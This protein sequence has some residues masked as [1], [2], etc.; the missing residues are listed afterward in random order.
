MCQGLLI[1]CREE[2]V[3][4]A[5]ERKQFRTFLMNIGPIS[6]LSVFA[7]FVPLGKVG[8]KVWGGSD[9]LYTVGYGMLW[10]TMW[11]FT[12]FAAVD[13]A[14]AAC[15]AAMYFIFA[16]SVAPLRISTRTKLGISGGMI[17]DCC[18]CFFALP[19]A[20][21]QMAAEDLDDVLLEGKGDVC[22]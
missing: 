19:W 16:L 12:I 6:F 2:A 4:L 13:K 8:S 10:V 9:V 15:G 1:V 18:V 20:I 7:P 17:S 22:L 3:Q 5:I 21:G 11:V 14:F